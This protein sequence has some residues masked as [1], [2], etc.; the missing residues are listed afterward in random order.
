MLYSQE[1]KHM[2]RTNLY[3]TGKQMERL[4][5]RSESKVRQANPVSLG[6]AAK[7]NGWSQMKTIGEDEVYEEEFISF[8]M[9]PTVRQIK[10]S[11][12]CIFSQC[13]VYLDSKLTNVC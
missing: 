9:L 5:E 4:K 1:E 3:L 2:K 10:V 7:V 12:A 11:G 13:C 6:N 8:L